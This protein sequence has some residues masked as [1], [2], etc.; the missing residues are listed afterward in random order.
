MEVETKYR[1]NNAYYSSLSHENYMTPYSKDDHGQLQNHDHQLPV[2]GSSSNP[3]FGF[4]TPCFDP[5]FEAYYTYGCYENNMGLL[6]DNCCNKSFAEY[7]FQIEE[8]LNIFPCRNPIVTFGSNRSCFNLNAQE[9]MK[10]LS[11]VVP[12][13]EVSS[14]MTAENGYNKKVDMNKKGMSTSGTCSLMKRRTYF[15]GRKKTNNNNPVK[16]QWTVEE[17]R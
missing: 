10:P 13:H 1:E 8:Y 6:Y 5:N 17:D 7:N 2:N 4:Q 15:N 14:C 3:I 11:F 16:G 9:N 12:E